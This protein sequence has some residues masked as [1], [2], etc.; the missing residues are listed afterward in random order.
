MSALEL[1][2]I[3]LDFL[4]SL[5]NINNTNDKTLLIRKYIQENKIKI[6]RINNFKS[7][8][9]WINVTQALS[10]DKQLKGKITVL[11]FFTYCCINCMHI[12]P[13]LKALE[14][15]FS[16]QQGVIVIGVHSPKFSNERETA[17]VEAAVKRYD[18]S[19]PVVND[20][21]DT[22]WNDLGICCWPTLCVIGP[23]SEPLLMLM[24]EG[25][26]E[27]LKLFVK[28]ALS[29]FSNENSISNHSIPEI[30]YN[31]KVS[32]P[33]VLKYP[34]KVTAFNNILAVADTGNHRILI[35]SESGVM[36]KIFGGQ[37]AGFNDDKG[38]KAKFHSPQGLVFLDEQT[39]F[40]ADTENHAI[41][42]IN[43]G[44]DNV[45]TVVRAGHS[46]NDS[47]KEEPNKKISSP[48]DLCIVN[49]SVLMIAMAGT[50]QI[51]AVFLKDTI[52]WQNK[53]CRT[54][55]CIPIA[56]SGREENR[57]N[58]YPMSAGFA[59]PSGITNKG[60]EFLFIADS[61]SSSVRCLN[62]VNG[63]VTGVVGGHLDPTNLFAF[64]DEDGI[65][66]KAKLQHPLG[67][68]W[69]EYKNMLYVADSYNHKIKVV[70]TSSKSCKTL[71]F[72]GSND[73]MLNEPGGLCTNNDKLYVADTNNHT[74]RILNLES[75][76]IHNL[77]I[78]VKDDT[79]LHHIP[80][81]KIINASMNSNGG[82]LKIKAGFSLPSD[83]YLTDGA[84]SKWTLTL[85]GSDWVIEEGDDKFENI[86]H[87]TVTV[88]A[89]ND[90]RNVII[91]CKLFMCKNG[92]C[93][94][95]AFCF[96]TELHFMDNA[97]KTISISFHN[98]VKL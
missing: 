39:L 6:T 19:H 53:K 17:N 2:E 63:K 94:A 26:G 8:L 7:G 88:P 98:D 12:L 47:D 1:K 68:V 13:D 56:G 10:F 14:E 51:W 80:I 31:E 59:Q 46:G 32:A 79:S 87:W 23:N 83:T 90:T 72:I 16:V 33:Q 37:G 20:L 22:M 34:G 36:I 4:E 73:F 18:I 41:R 35:I 75:F 81:I 60:D 48:W 27:L 52:W 65:G 40:V 57:N 11:D 77:E 64:G 74:I 21:N 45:S 15:M 30:S 89:C 44:D 38:I 54:G 91:K 61:E 3:S 71:D 84:P 82:S 24:G 49:Q 95:Q 69:S 86:K 78:K 58:A 62:L 50:H 85:P 66:N 43:L 29:I 97:D 5:S 55:T 96:T 67:V 25:H 92:I 42:K 28:E 93:M 70:D 9:E 76:Q